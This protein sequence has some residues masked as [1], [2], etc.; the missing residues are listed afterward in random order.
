[1]DSGHANDYGSFQLGDSGGIETSGYSSQ[2]HSGYSGSFASSTSAF[3]IGDTSYGWEHGN[4]HAGTVI[5]TLGDAS[6]HEW[7]AHGHLAT[8]T[9]KYQFCVGIKTLSGELT[10][11]KFFGESGSEAFDAGA[12]QLTYF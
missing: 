4:T 10:Q 3:I 7:L 11:I 2:G 5:L 9:G 8:S 12:I 1:M 6:D